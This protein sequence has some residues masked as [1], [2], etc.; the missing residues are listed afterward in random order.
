MKFQE[1]KVEFIHLNTKD[2]VYA[3]A[4]CWDGA[5]R[6][7]EGTSGSSETCVGTGTSTGTEPCGSFM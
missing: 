1:P 3:S 5:T 7:I 4:D 2:A 6:C